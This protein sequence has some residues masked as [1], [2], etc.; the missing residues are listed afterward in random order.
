MLR[1]MHLVIEWNTKALHNAEF[2]RVRQGM[3]HGQSFPLHI[4]LEGLWFSLLLPCCRRKSSMWFH[5]IPILLSGD[6]G[7][8]SH[9]LALEPWDF[10]SFCPFLRNNITSKNKLIL[11][12]YY[13][14]PDLYFCFSH[15]ILRNFNRLLKK[16][17]T[18]LIPKQ[19]LSQVK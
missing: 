4:W 14:E 17:L 3:A 9:L 8:F 16:I 5:I 12:S 13:Y 7:L 18:L 6:L 10:F 1:N 2:L 19:R 15:L 11:I